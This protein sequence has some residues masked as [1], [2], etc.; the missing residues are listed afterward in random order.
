MSFAWHVECGS[1]VLATDPVKLKM[2]LKNLIG[3]AMKFTDQGLVAVWVRGARNGI[4]FRVADTGIGIS[5]ES[6]ESIFEPF[7]QGNGSLA[8]R[9]GGVGLGLYIVRRLLGILGGTIAVESEVGRGSTFCVWLP[10]DS[11]QTGDQGQLPPLLVPVMVNGEPHPGSS[12]APA[13]GYGR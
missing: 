4:E 3:N 10:V 8:D 11:R 9:G 13:N 2:V 12:A 6:C 1:L 5:P 7:H